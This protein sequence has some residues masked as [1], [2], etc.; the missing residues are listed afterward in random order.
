MINLADNQTSYT[1][2]G[3][4]NGDYYHFV[5][6]ANNKNGSSPVSAVLGN[7]QPTSS[8]ST[9]WTKALD[10]DGSSEFA[11]FQIGPS[12]QHPLRRQQAGISPS[13]SVSSGQTAASGQPWAVAS[14]FRATDLST[15]RT[16]WSQSGISEAPDEQNNNNVRV[17]IN[18]N[19]GIS[20]NFGHQYNHLKWTS[21]NGLI[22]TNTWYGLYV[23]FNGGS[24]GAFSG[25]IT[26]Y[27]SRFRFKLVDLSTGAVT[28]V[29]SGGAWT[30]NNYGIGTGTTHKDV[31][32]YFYV[33]SYDTQSSNRFQGQIASTVITTLRTSQSLPDDT[34]VAMMVRDPTNWL[35]T[36]KV[37]N[38]WRKPNEDND[39]SSDFAT[40]SAKGEQGTKIWLMG[41]GTNDS[42]PNIASQ[43]N[44]SNS[45]QYLELDSASTTSVS[46]PGL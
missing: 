30:H 1:L 19:G 20:F 28:D 10:L 15:S 13:D 29:T 42:S 24:T 18:S 45:G 26:S 5:I 37:G 17:R 4:T 36:Y 34:E 40:G 35:Y 33:G 41:D 7:V 31:S 8:S 16:L 43:V 2:T 44:S 11:K 23:D 38:P 21:A 39:Y 12:E 6:R 3:L 22:S 27:Y 9:T 46:I 25:S 14:V 32:G